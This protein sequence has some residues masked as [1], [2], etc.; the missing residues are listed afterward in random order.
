MYH[1]S[2]ITTI[3]LLPLSVQCLIIITRQ[4]YAKIRLLFSSIFF[5]FFFVMLYTYY[6]FERRLNVQSFSVFII[7]E[8]HHSSLTD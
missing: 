4:L 8:T 6:L 7:M 3:V 1:V 2:S 5:N